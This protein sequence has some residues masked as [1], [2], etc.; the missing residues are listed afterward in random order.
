M[1]IRELLH[2]SKLPKFAEWLTEQ[3][4]TIQAVKGRYEVLRAKKPG[5]DTLIIWTRL[6]AKEHY[7]VPDKWRPLVRQF[8]REEKSHE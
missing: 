4:W 2:K 8:I 1:A 6:Y 3:G 5:R 7:T